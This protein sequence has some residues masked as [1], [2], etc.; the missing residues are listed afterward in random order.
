MRRIFSIDDN[1]DVVLETHYAMT[2]SET[3][4]N[5]S[6]TLDDAGIGYGHRLVISEKPANTIGPRQPRQDLDKSSYHTHTY[7]HNRVPISPVVC[8]ISA[9]S[10][11]KPVAM[12][13]FIIF[14]GAATSSS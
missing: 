7:T 14:S 13:V 10:P 2:M 12:C 3:L 1:T 11:D 8:I 9:A 5:L 4:N 6:L